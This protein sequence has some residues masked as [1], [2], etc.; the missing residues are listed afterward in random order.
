[1]LA[2]QDAGEGRLIPPFNINATVPAEVYSFKDIASPADLES[3]YIKDIVQVRKKE[4]LSQHLSIYKAQNWVLERIHE[5]MRVK[6][7][8]PKIRK[9]NSDFKFTRL[10]YH[11]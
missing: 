4:E 10:A 8:G 11:Y 1:L 5:A 7:S 6:K 2:G 3:I 9:V